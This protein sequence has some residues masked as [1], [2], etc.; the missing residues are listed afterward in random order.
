MG[1]ERPVAPDEEF[2]EKEALLVVVRIAP[3]AP[4]GLSVWFL[5]EPIGRF[6]KDDVRIRLKFRSIYNEPE[7]KGDLLVKDVL[8]V[9]VAKKEIPADDQAIAL[10]LYRKHTDGP[11]FVRADS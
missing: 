8:L 3:P 1:D 6:N 2:F 11:G 4:E 7:V 5:V 10:E 9:A